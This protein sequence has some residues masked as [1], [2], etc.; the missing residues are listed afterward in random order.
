MNKT[1]LLQW[2]LSLAETITLA[3]VAVSITLW[4]G[5][6]FQS[7]KDAEAMERRYQAQQAINDGRFTKIEGR[8]DNV[9]TNVNQIAVDVS[10]IRGRLEPKTK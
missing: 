10:Y 6:Q 3:G 2:R 8:L 9:S 5:T 4:L 7:R 1:T